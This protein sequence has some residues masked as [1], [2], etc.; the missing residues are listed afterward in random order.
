[1]RKRTDALTQIK[2][3]P[4]HAAEPAGPA[5]PAPPAPAPARPALKRRTSA[6]AVRR[7]KRE[8]PPRDKRRAR[9]GGAA[10]G[11]PRRRRKLDC[12]PD[13]RRARA[14]A[15]EDATGATASSVT[16]TSGHFASPKGEAHEGVNQPGGRPPARPAPATLSPAEVHRLLYI[17]IFRHAEDMATVPERR[18]AVQR[19]AD[20]GAGRAADGHQ[21]RLSARL[22]RRRALRPAGA[23]AGRRAH[24]ALRGLRHR[25]RAAV[26]PAAAPLGAPAPRSVGARWR[27]TT[28]PAIP[29]LR[30]YQSVTY[31]PTVKPCTDTHYRWPSITVM[32]RLRKRNRMLTA[33]TRNIKAGPGA[34]VA[35]SGVN[36]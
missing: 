21:P 23:R 31:G 12:R 22:P 25:A 13:S 8:T 34:R 26:S 3:R 16:R 10:G 17:F 28:A 24:A 36:N 14:C 18:G 9:D 27:R 33:D 30:P 7:F 2:Q 1:M 20:S 11:G 4:R 32:L 19:D 15:V 29:D 35:S 6:R 5:P